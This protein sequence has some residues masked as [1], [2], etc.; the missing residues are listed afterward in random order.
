M[1]L[2]STF[3]LKVVGLTF[4]PGYPG[5]IQALQA[6]HAGR[7]TPEML[8]VVLRRD[9]DNEHDPNAIEVH[10]PALGDDA[11]I[12]FV[13]REVAARLAPE[14]DAA[15]RGETPRRWKAG[16][17]NIRVWPHLPDQP[18]ITIRVEARIPDEAN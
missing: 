9:P 12:G 3:N 13:Q 17:S 16:V 7:T 14:M 4:R 1:P 5:N 2:P 11:F 10:V 18:G 15:D 8:T 6:I